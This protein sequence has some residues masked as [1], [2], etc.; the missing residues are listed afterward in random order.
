MQSS[1]QRL[2]ATTSVRYLEHCPGNMT[3]YEMVATSLEPT[4]KSGKWLVTISNFGGCIEVYE[5]SYLSIGYICEKVKT[6]Y[7][8]SLGEADAE[9][10]Q[11]GIKV[12]LA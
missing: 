9:A 11:S 3:R 7:G 6:R 1:N 2:D 8:G 4:G 10:I 12:L 5:D